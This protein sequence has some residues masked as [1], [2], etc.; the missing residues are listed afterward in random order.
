M[1][2]HLDDIASLV[3]GTTTV[4]PTFLQIVHIVEPAQDISFQLIFPES[5]DNH[6]AALSLLAT[7]K[8]RTTSPDN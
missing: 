8:S 2:N 5:E 7:H 6:Q 3:S 1:P 4:D